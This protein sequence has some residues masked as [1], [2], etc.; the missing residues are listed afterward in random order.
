MKDVR[1]VTGLTKAIAC[2]VLIVIVTG[3]SSTHKLAFCS[4]DPWYRDLNY[5]W[6]ENYVYV[7]WQEGVTDGLIYQWRNRINPYFLPDSV[8]TRA[9]FTVL[10][11][12]VFDLTPLA[13]NTP[14]YPDVPKYY[15]M[16][17][18]K[19]AWRWIEAA[20]AAGISS[21][22]K[23]RYFYPD[24]GISRQDAVDLLVRCLDLYDY[25]LSMSGKEVNNLLRRFRD[26][27]NTQADRRH[28]MACAIKFGIIQGY[29]D[30]TIRPKDVLLRCQAATIV[31]RSCLIRATA[32]LDV[33][34]PDGDGIDDTVE[35]DLSYLKNRGI[36]TWNMAIEDSSGNI[37]YTFNPRGRSGNPPNTLT[38][39][40]VNAKGRKV[41]IGRY[42]YQAWVKDRNNRQF[43][44]IKK[45]LD[46]IHYSL[47]GSLSPISCRDEQTLTV[48]AYTTTSARNMKALFAD[49]KSRYLSPSQN[50]QTWTLKLVMG[51]F[52]PPGSQQVSIIAD[53]GNVSRRITLSFKRIDNLWITPSISPNPAGPGQSLGIW[54]EASPNVD[55]VEVRLFGTSINLA[56]SGRLWKGTSTVPVECPE[57]DYPAVFTGFSGNR[58]VSSTINLRIDTTKL[59]DLIFS[60]TR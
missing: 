44:S 31:Y 43:F 27:M 58:K 39:K 21:T 1:E 17:Q 60:L 10:L 3:A 41:P 29:D 35:F 34:S 26:G 11:A 45:P 51:P 18:D 54:C 30:N 22:P 52:L 48:K 20:R 55:S 37:V 13:P 53:F 7:L 47:T 36:S 56:K 24:D 16:L 38:W 12:K 5:H 33:F 32:N 49:G 46:V 8:C 2:L 28:S 42:Y 6:A 25:A 40:G 23:G 19:P 50:K 15:T 14:S 4:H 9:Q 57:G 59:S